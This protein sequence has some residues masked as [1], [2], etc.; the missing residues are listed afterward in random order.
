MSLHGAPIFLGHYWDWDCHW[1]CVAHY[2][3]SPVN[4][5]LAFSDT[6]G[7]YINGTQ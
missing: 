3:A 4:N 5:Y 1:W 2:K 7:I 6:I